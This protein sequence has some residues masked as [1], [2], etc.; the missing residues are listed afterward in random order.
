M[1]FLYLETLKPVKEILQK[2]K[3]RCGE[4]NTPFLPYNIDTREPVAI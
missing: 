4:V 2:K 3:K 1:I